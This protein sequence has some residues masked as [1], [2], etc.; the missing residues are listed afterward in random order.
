[1]EINICVYV[2]VYVHFC[3]HWGVY[4]SICVHGHGHGHVHEHGHGHWHGHDTDMGTVID[5]KIWICIIQTAKNIESVNIIKKKPLSV[6]L[7]LENLFL[8]FNA[9][10]KCKHRPFWLEEILWKQSKH[11]FIGQQYNRKRTFQWIL[12]S[13]AQ[14]CMAAYLSPWLPSHLP[15]FSALTCLYVGFSMSECSQIMINPCQVLW[16]F[17]ILLDSS[18][19][20]GL[21][22]IE[23]SI[24]RNF[25]DEKFILR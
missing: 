21:L 10:S 4:A 16:I 2:H 15:T 22:P 20:C 7:T 6:K 12:G 9:I 18:L 5:M 17:D 13:C 8:S 24:Q 11:W 23:L 3:V 14:L 25:V 19:C 1:M